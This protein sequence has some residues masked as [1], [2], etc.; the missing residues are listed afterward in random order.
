MCIIYYMSINYNITTLLG[1]IIISALFIKFGVY[2]CIIK[3]NIITI[4][5]IKTLSI[6][7][8]RLYEKFSM[9]IVMNKSKE[10]TDGV[11]Q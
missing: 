9:P 2:N 4:I 3:Q 10:A 6:F 8:N 7:F 1:I 11:N 5:S